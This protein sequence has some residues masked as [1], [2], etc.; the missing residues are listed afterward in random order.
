MTVRTIDIFLNSRPP[1]QM[2]LA[3]LVLIA[4]IAAADHATGYEISFSVFYLIPVILSS[5][6]SHKDVGFGVCIVSALTW[7]GVEYTS[8]RA[9]SQSWILFWNAT[10][11]L[12]FFA[13]IAYLLSKLRQSLRIKEEL[14]RF[15][16]LT[17]VKSL[18]AFKEDAAEVLKSAARY[19]YPVS[20]G[21]IDLDGFKLLN[22]TM[23]HAVGDQA[24][25]VTGAQLNIAVRGTDITARTGG[26][27]FVVLVQ[28]ADLSAAEIFFGRVHEQ[29]SG[30]M[31]N[32]GWPIG[33]TIGVA[34]LADGTTDLKKA[35]DRAD[36]LML[37]TKQRGKNAVSF[38]VFAD[39]GIGG[40]GLL[41][42]AVPEAAGTSQAGQIC[43]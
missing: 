25:R 17:G 16:A 1:W 22:D 27:E 31:R 3:N 38:Q 40:V 2:A 11:R 18:R 21:F 4:I 33:F 24:L 5:W 26:D 14:I 37:A 20:L 39:T 7:L 34:V 12:I 13:V 8:G 42:G 29:L 43:L 32:R 28:H 23:G 35:L 15:D 30:A 10:T 9:Y 36:L 19:N 41:P 6:Y